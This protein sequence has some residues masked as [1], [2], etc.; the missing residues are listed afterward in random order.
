MAEHAKYSPSRLSRF[1]ACP[2]SVKLVDS[3]IHNNY[4]PA[5]QEASSYAKKGTELHD[6][7]HRVGLYGTDKLKD[8]SPDD[9]GLVVEC[10]EYLE[11]LEKGIGHTNYA[12]ASEVKVS[13]ESWGLP[14][15]WGTADKIISDHVN[16]HVDVVDW[17][18]GSGVLVNA[19]DNPQLLAYAAGAVSWP[20]AYKTVTM[21][22]FQPA[23]DHV[24]TWK[25][26][27]EELYNWVHGTLAVGLGKCMSLN[28]EIVPGVSQCRWCEAA[29]YCDTRFAYVQG[30]AEEL[31]LAQSLLPSKITP[32]AISELIK[33]APLL[34]SAIKE[35]KLFALNEIQR[36]RQIPGLKLVYGRSN[37]SWKNEKASIKW[38]S[39]NTE[40]DELFISKLVSPA[41]AEKLAKFLKKS[42]EFESLWEKSE[43]KPTLTSEKDPRP[44]ISNTT[45]A[46]DVFSD[47]AET[48]DKLE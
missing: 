39:T 15:V 46:I 22:I 7:V 6:H 45:Q 2:G 26:T 44:A 30:K 9:K 43:G 20:T 32:E 24:S 10:L 42:E 33:S 19:Q 5:E 16:L 41:Q 25:I 21:H 17:K 47:F 48:P 12:V 34:E 8:L 38:L 36:G 40:I 28:P 29:N 31:F 18:F 23:I 35:L 14:E 37:R 3:L 27:T 4:I 1:L 11:L 13:L